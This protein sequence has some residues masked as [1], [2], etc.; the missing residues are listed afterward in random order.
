MKGAVAKA[1]ELVA[2]T[3]N[4][5]MPQQFKNPANPEIHRKTTAEEI[6]SDTEGKVDILISGIGTGGTLTGVAEVIKKRKPTFKAIAVEPE[7]SPVLSGGKP[8]PHKIQGIGAGF[9]PEVLKREL[10]DEI[11]QVSNE[12]AGRFARQLAK[13]EGILAGISCGAALAA[14][15]RIARRP[16]NAGKMIVVILPDTGER[17]LST[18]LFAEAEPTTP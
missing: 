4:A 13:E 7:A 18:W 17:Y 1:E 5:F 3:P 11:I 9:I 2:K 15:D 10:I 12:D 8:G 14:A 16:E 6:W